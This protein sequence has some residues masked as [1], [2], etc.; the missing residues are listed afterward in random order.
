MNVSRI[1]TKRGLV[2]RYCPEVLSICYEAQYRR[3]RCGRQRKFL[4][5][6]RMFK[7]LKGEV[8]VRRTQDRDVRKGCQSVLKGSIQTTSLWLSM[9]VYNRLRILKELVTYCQSV[10]KY[11]IQRMLV[12]WWSVWVLSI[13]TWRTQYRGRWCGRCGGR[14]GRVKRQAKAFSKSS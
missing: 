3:S 11:S 9:E 8:S 4:I 12:V 7:V 6:L 2:L 13:C 5:A 10:L 14:C 1:R